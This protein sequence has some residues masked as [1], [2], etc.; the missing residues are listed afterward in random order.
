MNCKYCINQ[1]VEIS[2]AEISNAE[3]SNCVM[4]LYFPIC[5]QIKCDMR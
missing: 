4:V 5:A 2:N 1:I 3:I